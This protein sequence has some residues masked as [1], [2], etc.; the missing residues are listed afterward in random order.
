MM[1]WYVSRRPS[2]PGGFRHSLHGLAARAYD[3]LPACRSSSG[4]VALLREI[5][6]LRSLHF[7]RYSG[8]RSA[9]AGARRD[10]NLDLHPGHPPPD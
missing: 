10:L 3:R 4:N 8:L 6:I 1:A 2:S 5:E 9:P 7:L